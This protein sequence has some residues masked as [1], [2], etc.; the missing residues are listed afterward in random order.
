VSNSEA[1]TNKSSGGWRSQ[2]AQ[3]AGIVACVFIAKGAIAEPFYV[4]SGSME[5]TLLI[6]DALV[7]SKF[8]YGYGAASLPILAAFGGMLTPVLI[9]FQLNQGTPTQR[10]MAIPMATDIAFALGALSLL[11]RR[12]PVSLTIFLTAL[13]IIDDLGAIAVIGLFY[14][15]DFSLPFLLGSLA[16]FAG[17]LVLNRLG[18]RRLAF[19]LIPGVVM[20]YLM[21]KSG[22]HPTITGVLLAFAIP[23]AGG[24]EESP[25]AR[26][27]RFLGRPVIGQLRNAGG[28]FVRAADGAGRQAH[29]F[30]RVGAFAMRLDL[31]EHVGWNDQHGRYAFQNRSLGGVQSVEPRG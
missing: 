16:I 10:G 24:S 1:S 3:L 9:H 19:Y 5:P 4:P 20:W 22:I 17:L 12:V 26:L 13:A 6:G 31:F 7:A 29:A 21:G 30:V 25:S 2:V 8:P 28:G 27:E 11:G 14:S 15:K 18:V 23:F